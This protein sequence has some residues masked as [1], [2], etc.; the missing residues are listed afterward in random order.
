MLGGDRPLA[1]LPAVETD[2]LDAIDLD[3]QW[4]RGD[5]SITN[6]KLESPKA[7][8]ARLEL[9]HTPP[10]QYRLTAIV[11]PLDEPNGL[12][13]GQCAG[14]HRFVTLFNYLSGE[15]VSSAIENVDGQNVGN[16]TTFAGKL[17]KQ[18]QLSQLIVEVTD[19]SV[20]AFVDGRRILYGK[21]SPD[22]LSLGEYWQT[23]SPKALCLGAYDCRY[24]FHRLTL[25]SLSDE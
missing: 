3:K 15:Q 10:R 6:G 20:E 21:G 25:E 4:K 19:K 7:Y 17:F 1:E 13:L 14:P 16:E 5:W 2:L 12:L 9:S 23:P 8:G 18:H 24:R 22:R 11:E